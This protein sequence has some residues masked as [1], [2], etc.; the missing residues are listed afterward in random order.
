M[1]SRRAEGWSERQLGARPLLLFKGGWIQESL[2]IERQ[3]A[4][5]RSNNPDRLT[6][7]EFDRD[8]GH[9]ARA[10]RQNEG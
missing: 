8:V 9:C 7:H 6:I 3:N 10:A 4:E 1:A 5:R 2:A